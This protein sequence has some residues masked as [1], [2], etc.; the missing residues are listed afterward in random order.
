MGDSRRR[1]QPAVAYDVCRWCGKP[2]VNSRVPDHG[3]QHTWNCQSPCYPP[4]SFGRHN[5]EPAATA[6]LLDQLELSLSSTAG[7]E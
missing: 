3:W 2:I 7:S 5:A 4:E 6:D 1:G